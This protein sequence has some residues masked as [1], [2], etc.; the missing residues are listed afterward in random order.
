MLIAEEHFLLLNMSKTELLKRRRQSQQET[1]TW[2]SFENR[3]VILFGNF[4]RKYTFKVQFWRCYD[5]SYPLIMNLCITTRSQVNTFLPNT[6]SVI[7][8]VPLPTILW[9]QRKSTH[10]G[11]HTNTLVSLKKASFYSKVDIK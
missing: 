8:R 3:N 2:Y 5:D 4:K 11:L 7:L 1:I 9:Q 6:A 10:L